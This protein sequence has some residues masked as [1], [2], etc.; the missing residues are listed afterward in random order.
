[1]IDPQQY[2]LGNF[3]PRGVKGLGQVLSVKRPR[4]C[5]HFKGH[6][7]P[8]QKVFHAHRFSPSIDISVVM[9]RISCAVPTMP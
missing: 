7:A 5:D 1:M 9:R 8:L 4:V 3:T 6:M 2:S